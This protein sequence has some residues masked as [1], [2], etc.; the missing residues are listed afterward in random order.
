MLKEY[1]SGDMLTMLNLDEFGEKIEMNEVELQA[2][3]EST[4]KQKSGNRNLN[5]PGL[6]GDF[7]EI[8]FRIEDYISEEKQL[9]K[10]GEICYVNGKRYTV[11]SVTDEQ[12]MAH[13]MLAEYRQKTRK[14]I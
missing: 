12:G 9:M 2:V 1:L 4:T 3:L 13:L 10:Q 11:E 8:F 6:H 5:Y 14:N 7:L